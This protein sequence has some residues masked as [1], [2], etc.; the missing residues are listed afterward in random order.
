MEGIAA[1]PPRSRGLMAS[2]RTRST[3]TPNSCSRNAFEIH[4][5]VERFLLEPDNEIEIALHACG[6]VGSGS[7]YTKGRTP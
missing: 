1:D 5:G 4:V 6:A 2:F 3:R 7:E